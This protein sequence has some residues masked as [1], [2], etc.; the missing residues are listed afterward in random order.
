MAPV[1]AAWFPWAKA[2]AAIE[3][4]LTS[5]LFSDHLRRMPM[6]DV[7][8]FVRHN[9]RHFIGVFR[10]EYQAAVDV[11]MPPRN[12]ECIDGRAFYN[13][14]TKIVRIGFCGFD[15][16]FGHPVNELDDLRIVDQGKLFF[17]LFGEIPAHF[18][19]AFNGR[20]K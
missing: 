18:L 11:N 13:V 2:M 3:A 5:V 10:H 12:G 1:D 4:I 17:G 9:T 6:F 7:G 8:H 16:R 19:F 15:K 14:K 20:S